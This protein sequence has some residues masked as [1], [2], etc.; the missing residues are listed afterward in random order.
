MRPMLLQHIDKLLAAQYQQEWNA[1]TVYEALVGEWL[2]REVR[3]L[4]KQHG[5]DPNISKIPSR[6]E[7]FHACLRIAETMERQGV[8]VIEE[9]ALQQLVREDENIGWLEKFELG[10]R[11]LLNRNSERAFRFSHYTIQEFLLA[12]GLV[13]EQLVG[14]EP[15]RGT[16]Q[17]VRFVDLADEIFRH[18]EQ[19]DF[20]D[21]DPQGYVERYNAPC[22]LQDQLK[23]GTLGPEM[24]FLPGGLFQMGDM[25]GKGKKDERPVHEVKLDSFAIGRYPVTF[26]EYDLFCEATG[27]KKPKDKGW[28]RGEQPVIN[29]SWKDAQEYCKWLSRETGN[30]YRLPTEAEWEYACRAGSESAYCFGNDEKLLG[31]YAWYDKNSK[32]KTHP[33]GEKKPNAWGLHDMHGNVWEWCQDWYDN[34]YYAECQKQGVMRNPQG[35]AKGAGRVLRGG[36]YFLSPVGCRSV[37]RHRYDP[38]VRRGFIGFRLVL[39]FQAAGS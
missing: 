11:S 10:G 34:E 39:P 33:V 19:L 26:A 38:E 15:L 18:A 27:R 2:D 8:R 4:L 28:G 36:S 22:P 9:K 37:D 7:L 29:V 13:N 32:N 3:K 14:D 20:C 30:G 5:A 16:D 23:G 21:I 12:W 1:Y 24:I 35:P 31:E 6:D 17:L 25:Q